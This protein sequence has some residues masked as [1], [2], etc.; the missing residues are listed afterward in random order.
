M[1]NRGDPRLAAQLGHRSGD[2]DQRAAGLPAGPSGRQER[3][4]G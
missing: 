4:E 1:R 2:D 3:L